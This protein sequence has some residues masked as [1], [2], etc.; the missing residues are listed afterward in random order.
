MGLKAIS[1][2]KGWTGHMV[3]MANDIL[4][5]SNRHFGLLSM[6]LWVNLFWSRLH[7]LEKYESGLY[8]VTSVIE[9]PFFSY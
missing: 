2:S 7:G 3:N 8:R 6:K 1:E 4:G 9:Q 5:C